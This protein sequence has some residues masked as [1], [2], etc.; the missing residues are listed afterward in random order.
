RMWRR[1]G[2]AACRRLDTG[3]HQPAPGSAISNRSVDAA[4]RP[5]PCVRDRAIARCGAVLGPRPGAAIIE[6]RCRRS[7]EVRRP[8]TG[9]T[10]GFESIRFGLTVPGGAPDTGPVSGAPQAR[11]PERPPSREATVARRSFSEGGSGDRGASRAEAWWG[12]APRISFD[13]D[14]NIVEPG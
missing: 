1:G 8:D 5:G 13:T 9:R 7:V 14:W 3:V 12:E 2:A 6:D 10:G 4:G 11:P